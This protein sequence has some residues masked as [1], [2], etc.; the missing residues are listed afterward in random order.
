MIINS[1][2]ATLIHRTALRSQDDALEVMRLLL[3][4]GADV[5][6]KDLIGMTPLHL[7]AESWYHPL[8]EVSEP[9]QMFMQSGAN[10]DVANKAGRVALHLAVRNSR[11]SAVELLLYHGAEPNKFDYKGRSPLYY[12]MKSCP[13]S[14]MVTLLLEHGADLKTE[15]HRGDSPLHYALHYYRSPE[16][17]QLLLQHGA[18][19]NHVNRNGRIPLYTAIKYCPEMVELLSKHGAKPNLA[20]SSLWCIMR[21][22][23]PRAIGLIRVWTRRRWL[24]YCNMERTQTKSTIK[25]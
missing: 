6:V 18:D 23:T 22:T 2:G 7:V 3:A 1:S 17:V 8:V 5:N 25:G 13:R 4:H 10:I 21:C 20:D 15:D 9:I 24:F 16:T 14:E 11:A 19:L 12:A